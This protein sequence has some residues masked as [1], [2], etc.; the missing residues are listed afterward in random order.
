[1]EMHF[2]TQNQVSQQKL[3]EVSATSE[4]KTSKFKDSEVIF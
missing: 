4:Y 1:M 3:S 2:E